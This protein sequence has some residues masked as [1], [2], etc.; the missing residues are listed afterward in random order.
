MPIWMAKKLRFIEVNRI[1]IQ[2]QMF[3][4]FMFLYVYSALF[5]E[6][7]FK[8]S[9]HELEKYVLNFLYKI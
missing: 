9:K 8:C 3:N 4:V 5:L 2:P 6:F 7:I 1:G